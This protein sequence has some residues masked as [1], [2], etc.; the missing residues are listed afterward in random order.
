MF[1]SVNPHKHAHTHTHT[2]T[3]GEDFEAVDTRLSFGAKM[4]VIQ[5]VLIT[6]LDDNQIESIKMFHLQLRLED[7]FS[8]DRIRFIADTAAV[9]IQDNDSEL[10]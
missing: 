8:S 7:G 3:A 9:L 10:L 6:I 1:I 2:H 5:T 4:P